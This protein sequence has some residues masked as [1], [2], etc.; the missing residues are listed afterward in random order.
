MPNAERRAAGPEP[1]AR[2]PAFASGPERRSDPALPADRPGVP[3]DR[4]L[5]T[6]RYWRS[7]WRPRQTSAIV[8]GRGVVPSTSVKPYSW[9]SAAATR[10]R[11]VW[12]STS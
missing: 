12:R 7:G 10:T 5:S 1:E 3:Q 8:N 2:S 4:R 6:Q 9:A 11:P